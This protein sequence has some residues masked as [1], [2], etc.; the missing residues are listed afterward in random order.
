MMGRVW[1]CHVAKTAGGTGRVRVFLTTSPEM[2]GNV[3]VAFNTQALLSS[4]RLLA[5]AR[6]ASE[7][8]IAILIRIGFPAFA[9][10]KHAHVRALPLGEP[11]YSAIGDSLHR[12]LPTRRM[13]AFAAHAVS[14]SI[15]PPLFRFWLFLIY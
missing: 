12:P 4:A 7:A 1:P 13:Q 8:V 5:A 6:T 11:H 9:N 15:E 10:S 3:S 2:R 14:T